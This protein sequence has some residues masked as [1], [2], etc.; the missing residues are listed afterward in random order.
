[1][2][3]LRSLRCLRPAAP[4][5]ETD[6]WPCTNPRRGFPC[7]GVGLIRC[8][9]TAGSGVAQDVIYIE[10]R[11]ARCHLALHWKRAELREKKYAILLNKA[12]GL[13]GFGLLRRA[14]ERL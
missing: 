7:P 8:L 6:G 4:S 5:V 10:R 2:D 1:M 14:W 13:L 9:G 12:V 3:R 11:S